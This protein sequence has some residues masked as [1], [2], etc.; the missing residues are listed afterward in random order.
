VR[1][2]FD[3]RIRLSRLDVM[4]Y[5][6]AAFELDTTPGMGQLDGGQ[7]GGTYLELCA[8]PRFRAR[9]VTLSLPLKLGLTRR[10]SVSR[11]RRRVEPRPHMSAPENS[12]KRACAIQ[13]DP[14]PKSPWPGVKPYA[15]ALVARPFVGR[16]PLSRHGAEPHACP[17]SFC[18]HKCVFCDVIATTSTYR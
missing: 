12:H 18:V 4:P 14:L 10:A 5:L 16:P 3:E 1:A 11:L 7:H 8:A 15:N 9:R 6:M 13:P 17:R 2:A